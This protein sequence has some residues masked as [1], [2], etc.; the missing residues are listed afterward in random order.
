[1]KKKN[2]REKRPLA[3]FINETLDLP[4]DM[5]SGETF[6]EIRAQSSLFI[7]GARKILLYSPTHIR[8]STKNT[9]FS[10]VGKRLVC[11]SYHPDG[12]KI[13]GH[14]TSVYFEEAQNETV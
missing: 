8:L 11:A 3:E 1:M 10:V 13:D 12:I 14:I 9:V 2:R 6:I 4:P 5:V 7:T